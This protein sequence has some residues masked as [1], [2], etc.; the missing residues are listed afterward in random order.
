MLTRRHRDTY[1]GLRRTSDSLGEL[2]LWLGAAAVV[3]ILF[4]PLSADL[5]AAGKLLLIPT[6]A[7]MFVAVVLEPGS[8]RGLFYHLADAR[9]SY[10][11]YC[12]G[13]LLRQDAGRL[14]EAFPRS[15]P[16]D[17]AQESARSRGSVHLGF[18]PIGGSVGSAERHTQ[19]HSPAPRST[20]RIRSG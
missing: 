9:A 18:G 1:N 11:P 4:E 10:S 8:H 19:G 6:G 13:W 20:L 15:T 3:F 2:S 14:R 5:V 12:F 17:L 7:L 16:A